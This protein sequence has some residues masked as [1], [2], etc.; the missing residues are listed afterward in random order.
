VI[1]LHP[2]TLNFFRGYSGPWRAY[3]SRNNEVFF[4]FFVLLNDA[5]D[6]LHFAIKNGF[7]FDFWAVQHR[8]FPVNVWFEVLAPGIS[9]NESV[10]S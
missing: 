2:A 8:V 9:E 3:F 6:M 1:E 4:L 10:L 5:F 7:Y